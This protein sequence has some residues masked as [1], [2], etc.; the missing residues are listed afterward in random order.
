M[1]K[2]MVTSRAGKLSLAALALIFGQLPLG[3]AKADSFSVFV[4]YADNLRASGFFPTPWIGSTF[5]GQSVISQ[6]NPAGVIFDSGAVRIDNTGANPIA[7]SNFMVTDNNGAVVFN[8]W[9]PGT[10]LTL[11]PG[12]SGIFTQFPNSNENFDSSDQGLF[13][14][15]PPANLEPNNADGNGNTNLIGGCS[16]NPTF[17]TAGQASGVCNVINAP[18][19]SFTENGNPVS[20]VD[21][22]FILNTGEYD[23]LNN[24]LFGEDGNESINWN[25][26]GTL[27]SRGG[28]SVPEPAS[29]A[30]LGTALIGFAAAHR[31]RYS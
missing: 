24:N 11:A 25:A 18:V 5:N 12:Q 30:L 21:T 19:V 9:G 17:F 13:G 2:E 4:G 3:A 10:Q 14:G 23:F 31:R 1:I 27:A 15:T 20:F 7:I 22:G 16:S 26:I 29:L 6:T 28:T 8:I